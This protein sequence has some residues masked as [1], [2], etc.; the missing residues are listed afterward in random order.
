MKLLHICASPRLEGSNTLKVSSAVIDGLA[1]RVPDLEVETIDLFQGDLPAMA[2]D[3]IEAKYTLM[4]NQPIDRA[5]TESWKQIEHEIERFRSADAYVVTAPIWNFGIP[6]TLK[7]YIDCIVQPGYMFRYNEQGYPV[8]LVHGKKMVVSLSSGG[9]YS[10][11]SPM[12]ALNF[13][14]PYLRAIFGFIG[15]TDVTF[16]NAF[17]MDVGPDIR[18]ASLDGA[19]ADARRVAEDDGWLELAATTAA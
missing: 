3:N 16:V 1:E 9:D 17:A 4:M 18:S 19:L 10:D 15:I 12:H 13:N 6:Y 2:G 11:A 14:E 5:H 7:Y 8:P